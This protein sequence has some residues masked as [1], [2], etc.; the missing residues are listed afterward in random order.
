MRSQSKLRRACDELIATGFGDRHAVPA[1]LGHATASAECSWVVWSQIN[2]QSW[3]LL[4]TFPDEARCRANIEQH[5]AAL[6]EKYPGSSQSR[7]RSQRTDRTG[8]VP[9]H[10]QLPPRHHRPTRAENRSQ[11]IKKN[12][13]R[14]RAWRSRSQRRRTSHDTSR[15]C[16]HRILHVGDHDPLP[17]M[18]TKA[19]AILKV[20]SGW[21]ICRVAASGRNPALP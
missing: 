19:A 1:R 3:E 10:I 14:T 17:Y 15:T 12:T 16:A 11:M 21:P 2:A 8:Q 6:V 9:Q 13:S 18:R 4:S 7:V 5:L 20:A